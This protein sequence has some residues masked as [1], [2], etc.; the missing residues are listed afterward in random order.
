MKSLKIVFSVFCVTLLFSLSAAAQTVEGIS[1]NHRFMMA[2]DF[3]GG[4]SVATLEMTITNAGTSSLSDVKL[5]QIDPF[6]LSD[7]LE[8]ALQIDILPAGGR[9][10]QPWE[11]F[12][13]MS[14]DQIFPVFS[15]PI[16]LNLSG[17]DDFGQNVSMDIM[18]EGGTE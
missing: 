3:E 17:I 5:M 13:S 2:E 4:G 7:P 12:S 8:Q 6:T 18:S 15:G 10:T 16:H 11:L 14:A 9:S 1:V